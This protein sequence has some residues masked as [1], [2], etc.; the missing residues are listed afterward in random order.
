MND[1]T[2]G[3]HHMDRLSMWG[4]AALGAYIFPCGRGWKVEIDASSTPIVFKTKTEALKHAEAR[5]YAMAGRL[6]WE[7]Y[8]YTA[9]VRP[10]RPTALANYD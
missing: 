9:A 7:P 1:Y 3:K 10:P 2:R 8:M 6:D 5:I 4:A